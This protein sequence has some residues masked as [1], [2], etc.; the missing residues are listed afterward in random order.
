[1]LHSLTDI[2][3]IYRAGFGYLASK[4][5]YDFY[6]SIPYWESLNVLTL[7]TVTCYNNQIT[8]F[9]A[10]YR[11]PSSIQAVKTNIVEPKTIKNLCS[12][13]N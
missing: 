5:L 10:Q 1:M 11:F 13:F 3:G 2:V 4:M 8:P 9:A 6:D 7:S 12:H